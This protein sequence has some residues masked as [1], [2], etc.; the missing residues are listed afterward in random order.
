[1]SPV[2]N[3][4]AM[5]QKLA[6]V[7]AANTQGYMAL[8]APIL[9]QLAQDAGQTVNVPLQQGTCYR[10]IAAGGVGVTDLDLHVNVN[11]QRVAADTATNDTPI[12]SYCAPGQQ[13]AQ[14]QVFMYR[15]NGGFAFQAF[16]RN[17]GQV[18]QIAPGGG[19]FLTNRMREI[20]GRYASGRAPV[21]P[22]MRGNLQTSQTQDFSVALQSG[23]CYTVVGVG[24]PSVTDLD[25]FLFDGMGT[26]V[27]QDQATDNFPI[28]QTC[29]SV[30]SNFR[31]Q[32]KMYS[33]YGAFGI[34]VFGN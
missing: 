23:H 2:A 1:M 30:P 6:G 13:T 32:V 27:A 7:V 15:G 4:A 20:S 31:I 24:D 5:T 11:G 29:P 8:G 14:V 3:N 18:V 12:A 17:Q 26:Q 33:G 21:S 16:Q 22:L 28:V 25:L 34:Q 9:G 19:D 10:F